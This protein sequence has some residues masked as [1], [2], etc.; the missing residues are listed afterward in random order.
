M[1]L[2]DRLGECMRNPV[3]FV[4]K[5]VLDARSLGSATGLIEEMMELLGI[6]SHACWVSMLL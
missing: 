5:P 3:D 4:G 2:V 6:L 1:A